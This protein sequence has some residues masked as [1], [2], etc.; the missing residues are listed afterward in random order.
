MRLVQRRFVRVRVQVDVSQQVLQPGGDPDAFSGHHRSRDWVGLRNSG[1]DVPV[2]RAHAIG[3][4]QSHAALD[5]KMLRPYL[6]GLN[7][8]RLRIDHVE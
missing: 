5:D 1:L 3:A 8:E 2:T 6:V 7:E 4:A